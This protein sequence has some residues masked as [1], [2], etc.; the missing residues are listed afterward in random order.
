[1]KTLVPALGSLKPDT[2]RQPAESAWQAAS[3]FA[4]MDSETKD[5]KT[6]ER[7]RSPLQGRMG[8]L[9]EINCTKVIKKKRRR[10]YPLERE[11]GCYAGLRFNLSKNCYIEF[12]WKP[13][14]IEC[15][16]SFLDQPVVIFK[17]F[18]A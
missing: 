2:A 17:K 6:S 10:F 13:H 4:R 8:L 9:R 7:S 14:R 11:C 12:A 3:V 5:E 15:R 1:M 18:Y 16:W